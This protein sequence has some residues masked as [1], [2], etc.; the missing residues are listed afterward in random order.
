MYDPYET[1]RRYDQTVGDPIGPK[2]TTPGALLIILLVASGCYNKPDPSF[3]IQV[4]PY[5]SNVAAP[6]VIVAYNERSP[7]RYDMAVA[8]EWSDPG[9]TQP[10]SSD[11]AAG[12]LEFTVGDCLFT[13]RPTTHGSDRFRLAE[14]ADRNCTA[15]PIVELVEFEAK[16]RSMPMTCSLAHVRDAG[17]ETAD[18]QQPP[19]TYNCSWPTERGQPASSPLHPHS[20]PIGTANSPS[21]NEVV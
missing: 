15:P 11:Q 7:G 5:S 19:R 3:Y 18:P 20:A 8:F 4:R 17:D 13:N 12:D 6:V 21:P 16:H 2:H 10:F 9:E 14:L 1:A